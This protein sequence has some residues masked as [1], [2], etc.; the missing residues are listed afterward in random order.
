[1]VNVVSVSGGLL[2]TRPTTSWYRQAASGESIDVHGIRES[3]IAEGTRDSL[4]AFMFRDKRTG[5]ENISIPNSGFRIAYN[6]FRDASD[7]LVIRFEKQGEAAT[8]VAGLSDGPKQISTFAASAA[9]S[10]YQEVETGDAIDP[11]PGAFFISELAIGSRLNQA[12][13]SIDVLA[14]KPL[15]EPNNSNEYNML[16][17][18]RP[19]S[20]VSLVYT[21]L[22]RE[23]ENVNKAK[24]KRTRA[25]RTE[26]RNR[27]TIDRVFERH[28]LDFG[29]INRTIREQ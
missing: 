21:E 25:E 23:E 7:R 1:M 11:P 10:V 14:A 2:P 29:G 16:G 13:R 17:R 5:V 8:V 3:S 6:I 15:V 12:A 19:Q 18:N 20:E 28:L 27:R 9:V 4:Q 24:N 22:E 26:W